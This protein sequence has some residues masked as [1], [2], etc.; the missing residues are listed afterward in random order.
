MCRIARLSQGRVCCLF[1]DARGEDAEIERS[2][3]GD[4][5]RGIETPS[6]VDVGKVLVWVSHLHL[7]DDIDLVIKGYDRGDH[8]KDGQPDQVRFYSRPEDEKLACK[9]GCAGNAREGEEEQR[10]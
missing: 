8:S 10:Q 7:D 1:E 9:S 5:Q 2:D 3:G 6:Q 4:Q